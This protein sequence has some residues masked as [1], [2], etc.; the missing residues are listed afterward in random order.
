MLSICKDVFMTM[1]YKLEM[2][3]T[4]LLTVSYVSLL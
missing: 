4:E 3:L 2:K 1:I